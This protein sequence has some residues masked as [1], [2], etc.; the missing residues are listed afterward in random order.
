MS[1][2]PKA[3]LHDYL[4]TARAALTW[5]LDGLSEYDVRRPMTSTG[6]NLL[7]LVKH[8][9]LVEAWFF[10]RTF[11]RPFPESLPWWDDDA[12]P[13]AD[14]WVTADES[15]TDVVTRYERACRHADRT[16]EELDLAAPGRVP[17][18]PRPDVTLHVML[19]HVLSETSRHAGH[20][21]IIR[22][23]LDGAV[24]SGAALPQ[25]TDREPADWDRHR[26]RIEQA[27]RS[28]EPT[29]CAPSRST[30]ADGR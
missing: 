19:V 9:T 5:K 16:I 25:L 14:L 24:G 2:Q 13:D 23:H 27:A 29:R 20:A 21:D 3:T 15:R 11:G 18:W 7:G 26:A 1:D 4:R 10:G 30:S 12:E 28:E 6:T 22:E 8:L 17:G